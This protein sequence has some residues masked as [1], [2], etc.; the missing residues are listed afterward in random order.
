LK[1]GAFN[2]L[3]LVDKPKTGGVM[4]CDDWRREKQRLA[5][6]GLGYAGLALL[7]IMISSGLAG[8]APTGCVYNLNCLVESKTCLA[9]LVFAGRQLLFPRDRHSSV[10]RWG[11][12]LLA[13]FWVGAGVLRVLSV[14]TWGRL[15]LTLADA[16]LW[17]VWLTAGAEVLV[18]LYC[19]WFLT[20]S[21]R[22]TE[23]TAR[24]ELF[25]SDSLKLGLWL[26]MLLGLT[27]F[28]L[29]S[30]YYVDLGFY[31]RVLTGVWIGAESFFFGV[32]YLRLAG[33]IWTEIFRLDQDLAA[34][35]EWAATLD[36]PD[37]SNDGA[38]IPQ[39]LMTLQYRLLSRNYLAGRRGPLLSVRAL[40][41]HLAMVGLLLYLP[42]LVG[43]VIEV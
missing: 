36:W 29:V 43:I 31:S 1:I 10:V 30:F 38:V 15:F 37:G 4:M 11:G 20:P 21:P 34:D 6:V 33:G 32:A 39:R 27:F 23:L 35:L 25:W 22:Y 19:R 8:M 28:Y 12:G 41:A 13:I 5:K 42:Q 40:V 24:W 26:A 16:L 3:L 2:L 9:A 14:F 7:W 17:T 18:A